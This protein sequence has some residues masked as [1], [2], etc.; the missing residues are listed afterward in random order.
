MY[1]RDIYINNIFHSV[2]YPRNKCLALP[3]D[4]NVASGQV[5]AVHSSG[6]QGRLEWTSRDSSSVDKTSS[7]K[8]CIR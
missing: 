2:G 8:H 3:L 7:Y 6:T 4:P 1:V 5:L